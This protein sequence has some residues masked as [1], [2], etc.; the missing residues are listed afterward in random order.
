MISRLARIVGL[1][2]WKIILSHQYRQLDL[3]IKNMHMHKMY[4]TWYFHIDVRREI[5]VEICNVALR[6]SLH[7]YNIITIKISKCNI[8][9][10][11]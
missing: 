9:K 7:Q 11:T 2:D 5:T 4:F 1:W 10:N 8:V 6:D 3:L